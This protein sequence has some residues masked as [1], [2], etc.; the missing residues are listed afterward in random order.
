VG[1]TGA[2]GSDEGSES[3][4][5]Q[6]G[7]LGALGIGLLLGITGPKQWV[8]SIAAMNVILRMPPRITHQFAALGV[9]LLMG[10]S[11]VA[12]PLLIYFIRPQQAQ[13]LLGKLNDWIGGAMRYLVAGVL[14]LIGVYFIWN[15]AEVFL[16]LLSR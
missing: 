12:I 2:A 7:M 4:E 13:A 10:I 14:G 5:S 11:L 16:A 9:Y 1:N 3:V 6:Q 8:F 15:G